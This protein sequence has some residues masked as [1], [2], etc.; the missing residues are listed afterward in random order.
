MS[1][2]TAFL[3]PDSDGIYEGFEI[4]CK[5]SD[6]YTG[7]RV[8]VPTYVDFEHELSIIRSVNLTDHAYA[9]SKYKQIHYRS[10]I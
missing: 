2:G 8:T 3:T 7:F 10:Y 4:Q 6:T 9:Q 5:Y 1:F